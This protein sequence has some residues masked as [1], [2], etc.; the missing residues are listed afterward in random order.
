VATS[1]SLS[2]A[3]KSKPHLSTKGSHLHCLQSSISFQQTEHLL[4]PHKMSQAKLHD[5]I[6]D[7]ELQKLAG[8][9][10]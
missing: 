2:S 5:A 7:V 10:Q 4:L 6:S 1:S 8:S 3:W 9:R